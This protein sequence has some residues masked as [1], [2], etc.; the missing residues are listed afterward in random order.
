MAFNSN[1]DL[2]E[3]AAWNA[4]LLANDFPMKPGVARASGNIA[5]VDIAGQVAARNKIVKIPRAEKP[6]GDAPTYTGSGY[7]DN[8]LAF[9][10]PELTMTDVLY[11]S[12]TVDKWDQNFALPDLINSAVLP[13]MHNIIDTINKN[14]LKPE[15]NKFKVAVANL[16]TTETVLDTADINFVRRALLERHFVEDKMMTSILT[17]AGQEDLVNLGLFQDANR[18]GGIDVQ[19]T[20]TMGDAFGFEYVLDNIP[21]DV[22]TDAACGNAVVDA[23]ASV[24]A[25]VVSV[26]N[27]AGAASDNTLANGDIV[28]FGTANARNQYYVVESATTTAITLKEPLRDAVADNATVTGVSGSCQYFY[29]QDSIALI[30]ALPVQSEITAASGVT[31]IPFFEPTNRIN[32][33]ISIEGDRAGAKVTIETLVGCKN[34]YESRGARYIRG[35]TAKA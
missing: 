10:Q 15:L 3:P 14:F 17:P 11:R 6:T 28:F 29:D 5:G 21:F 2:L 34:F 8:T 20:G 12:F 35:N 19:R 27:G 1:F 24:G 31:R 33:M 18:R 23:A 4:L 30:T 16:N 9:A 25:T 13:R 26:D 32:F 22:A 7:T